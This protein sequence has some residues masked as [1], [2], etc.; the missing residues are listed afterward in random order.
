[1]TN[2]FKYKTKGSEVLF[3][4]NSK[5]CGSSSSVPALR[6]RLQKN[7]VREVSYFQLVRGSMDMKNQRGPCPPS[8]RV[9]SVILQKKNL[10]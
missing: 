7:G 3:G 5:K 10:T 6:T 2:R 4:H 1:M 8:W 9:L